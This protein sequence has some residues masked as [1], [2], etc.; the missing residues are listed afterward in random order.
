[1]K[2]WDQ[3]PWFSFSECWALS[4]QS[5]LFFTLFFHFHQEA[6][7]FL[8]TFCHKGGVICI[9]EVLDISP[10]NLDIQ[11]W[12]TSFP[13]WNQFVVPCPVL[14]VAS[15]PAYRFH[16]PKRLTNLNFSNLVSEKCYFSLVLICISVIV[17]NAFHI[18]NIYLHLFFCELSDHFFSLFL[19]R[20][21][22]VFLILLQVNYTEILTLRF[23]GL[24]RVRHDLATDDKQ[25]QQQ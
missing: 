4:Q 17:R 24:Q 6:F 18:L 9:S 12:R 25:Q 5:W 15:W 10:S 2:W 20:N 1:M 13:I 11:P 14:T 7:E 16:H 22:C 23:M 3:M 19:Y 8:F 21:F